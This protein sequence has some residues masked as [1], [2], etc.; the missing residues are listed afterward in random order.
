MKKILLSLTIITILVACSTQKKV[1]DDTEFILYEVLFQSEY[2]GSEIKFYELVTEP[3]EFKM[4]LA[5]KPLKGKISEEDIKTSNFL[6]LNSG[7]KSTGGYAIGVESVVETPE[8]IVVT[9]LEQS[10][11]MG[12]NVTMAISYPMCVVKIN[13]KKKIIIK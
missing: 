13:S 8:N 4:L 7:M 1:Q 12:E 6:L 5:M 11:K 9:V 10:P 2:L 3:N